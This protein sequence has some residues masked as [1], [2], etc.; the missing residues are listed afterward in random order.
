MADVAF[1]AFVSQN[2][3]LAAQMYDRLLME[4]G[5]VKDL[6]LGKGDCL[7]R[8]GNLNDAFDCYTRALAMGQVSPDRLMHLVTSVIETVS[9]KEG[10]SVHDYNSE[11]LD[12]FSCHICHGLLYEPVTI[13]CGHTFCKYCMQK[14]KSRICKKCN[15]HHAGLVL[16]TLKVNVV[17]SNLVEKCF[18][19]G[20]TACKLKLQGNQLFSEK[21]FEQAVDIYTKALS[22]EP[23]DH[24]LLSNR[25]HAYASLSKH[26]EALEDAERVCELRPDWPKGF[27][28]KGSA[29][30]SLCRHEEALVAFMQ[31][32]VLDPSE[33]SAR[34]EL[35]K[36]LHCLLS[37]LPPENMK[38]GELPRCLRGPIFPPLPSR[39]PIA[40]SSV[41]FLRSAIHQTFNDDEETDHVSDVLKE[42]ARL[43]EE[44][45]E[46]RYLKPHEDTN[47]GNQ[48][49]MSHY[50]AES[51]EADGQ[52]QQR[53]NVDFKALLKHANNETDR[54]KETEVEPRKPREVDPALID[55]NDYECSLC[56]RLYY[57][58]VTTPCGHM[59]CRHCLDRCLDHNNKCPLCKYSL[60]E[61]LAERR[62]A[63]TELMDKMIENTMKS[64]LEERKKIHDAEMEE[65]ARYMNSDKIGEI[66]V[67][68][69]T[70]AYPTI[71]CPLHI[72]EPRYRLMVRQCMETGT[73]Q[74]GMCLPSNQ[75][76][77][78][79]YGCML[80]IR[81]VQFFP[82]GRSVV[83]AIG[84]RRFKVLDRGMRDGYHTAKVEFL[85]DRK[86]EGEEN[87][88]QYKSLHDEI[89]EEAKT[90]FD[91][92]NGV[93]KNRILTHF[94][95]M[96][97]TEENPESTRHG[98]KW[99]WWLLAVLPLDTR[100][101]MTIMAMRSQ[102][103]RLVA[104]RRV[105]NYVSSQN[106]S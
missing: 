1:E 15:A 74:F 16:T 58:P 51:S 25:S 36:V 96:P 49:E 10:L 9:Q 14:N 47:L 84:G 28:R 13:P 60:I 48:D 17:L 43:E 46:D 21:K 81:D 101:Q 91:G 24:L 5:P 44:V 77:F 12:M 11:A 87:I 26:Q 100:A 62:Q 103:D 88:A 4:Q 66:P 80:E 63:V 89:Y 69:C 73:R 34:K 98:P 85:Q 86:I 93:I 33:S 22:A 75:N 95:T 99:S 82:D 90:W 53:Q 18:S 105:L 35:A 71:P 64:E 94:G 42:S 30:L 55:R 54:L 97:T 72:F 67:F 38:H 32:L 3:D 50:G 59:F 7:A 65:L 79:E 57:Q 8:S 70:L 76:P 68:V 41:D 83:D 106:T 19:T 102:R 27:F 52:D 20:T 92:L 6:Y 45:E 56:F 31:C 78:V 104:L 39:P 61:Y 29:L 40:Q 2:Y 23:S 37:P